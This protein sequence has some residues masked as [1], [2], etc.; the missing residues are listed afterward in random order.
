MVEGDL[1]GIPGDNNAHCQDTHTTH[2]DGGVHMAE[3]LRLYTE[4]AVVRGARQGRNRLGSGRT[5]LT[6]PLHPPSMTTPLTCAVFR[7]HSHAR[8]HLPHNITLS[9]KMTV[10]R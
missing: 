7:S 8:P 10:I 4:S 2:S 3:Y 1:E 5:Q 9:A 6:H